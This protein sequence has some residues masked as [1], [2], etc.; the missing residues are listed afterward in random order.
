MPNSLEERIL[1]IKNEN[2]AFDNVILEYMPFITKCVKA[3]TLKF[4]SP[5]DEEIKIGIDAFCDAIMLFNNEK[6][7]FLPFAKLVIKNRLIDY[8]RKNKNNEQ[9]V[10]IAFDS[11]DDIA[12]FDEAIKNYTLK[13][14]EEILKYEVEDFKLKL[15]NWK[16]DMIELVNDCPKWMLT[17]KK[18]LK[19]AETIS[20]CDEILDIMF[21]K[22]Y[23][24]LSKIESKTF[25]KRKFLEKYRKYIISVVIILVGDY[26]YL[27]SF[28]KGR[29]V[30][31]ICCYWG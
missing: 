15:L 18:C 2:V 12:L 5:S 26:D 14:E 11:N 29:W 27:S 7:K 4:V 28:V 22:Y 24:P 16:I 25:E 6:G 30:Y 10:C 23:L 3:A 21:S 9:G 31:E 17:R 1:L 20:K 13:N 19:I 8:I